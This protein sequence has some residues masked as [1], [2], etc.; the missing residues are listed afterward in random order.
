[1]PAV[2]LTEFAAAFDRSSLQPNV[3]E[4]E[5]LRQILQEKFPMDSIAT[6]SLEKYAIGLGEGTLCYEYEFGSVQ[7]GS[8]KGGNASKFLVFFNK[9]K[10]VWKSTLRSEPDAHKAWELLR[11]GLVES[12]QLAA[13]G[14]WEEID[15]NPIAQYIPALR[16]KVLHVF[17][18]DDLL[19][20]FSFSHLKRFIADLGLDWKRPKNA[21][22]V[23]ANR[24]LLQHLRTIPELA[25]W[26]TSELMPLLYTW[27][28]K[29]NDENEVRVFKVAPGENAMY[30][31]TCLEQ[32][33]MIIGWGETG[34]LSA[35]TSLNDVKAS[36]EDA[37]YYADSKMSLTKKS[38]EVWNF[39][40]AKPGDI[41]AANRGTSQILALGTVIDPGYEFV[42]PA[43]VD[44]SDFTHC[45]HVEWDTS[46]AKQI[47]AQGEW[48]FKT[49][50]ELTGEVKSFVLGEAL[51]AIDS[52][53]PTKS[54]SAA[55]NQILYGPPGTGKTY[56]IIREAA[57]IVSGEASKQRYDHAGWPRHYPAKPG[58]I[59]RRL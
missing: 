19:P 49:V 29:V 33:K 28:P 4:A 40:S 39:V 9:G 55:L 18:P 48:V 20:I 17:Y 21:Y 12:L 13:A 59:T 44:S 16:A 15:P 53:S 45:L 24:Y 8:I 32:G 23:T 37:G 54:M 41:I 46:A 25:D 22:T 14:R 42:S 34:D 1:M 38:K 10:G 51:P 36:M 7:L 6:L 5:R 35:A 57:S 26:S 58:D 30:W 11:S 43:L 3:Q 47:P 27:S 56:S 52:R 50:Q 2:S 31:E